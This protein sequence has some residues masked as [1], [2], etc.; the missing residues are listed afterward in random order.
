[1]GVTI[2]MLA[3]LSL[4]GFGIYFGLKTLANF[5]P[6]RN[7]IQ[8]DLKVLKA[9]LQPFINDLVP[10][11]EE[12]M[13][14]LS[15]N[16]IRKKANKNIVKSSKG[17]F[18]TVYQEPLIA[19]AYRKYV[20]SK[21][22]ALLYARTSHHEFIYRIK[23]NMVE[24][25]V[26]DQLLGQIDQSGTMYPIKGRKALAQVNRS[27]EGLGLPILVNQKEV[28]RLT[29]LSKVESSNPRAFK[30]VSKMDEEEEKVFLALSILEM[31]K[32]QV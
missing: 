32:K 4:L 23:K 16:T 26:D 1:M 8:R 22:N 24:V 27:S 2:A 20:S 10:W 19:W 25:V 28:G 21:E 13:G 14:Q 30:V 18:T 7:K 9:D 31:V 15:L 12:E 5:N 11:T 17:I 6:G 29:D 3:I